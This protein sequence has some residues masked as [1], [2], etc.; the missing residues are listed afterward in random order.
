M[1][2]EFYLIYLISFGFICPNEWIMS[3]FNGKKKCYLCIYAS[4]S[5]YRCYKSRLI[6]NLVVF[7]SGR[8]ELPFVMISGRLELPFLPGWR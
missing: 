1:F 3:T 2:Q 7:I 5:C 4:I 6:S 8:L